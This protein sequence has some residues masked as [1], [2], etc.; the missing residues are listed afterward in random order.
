MS[1]FTRVACAVLTATA[2]AAAA[3][4]TAT[5]AERLRDPDRARD[6]VELRAGECLREPAATQAEGDADVTPLL[7]RAQ[8]RTR[9]NESEDAS[10][11]VRVRTGKQSGA[12]G[13]LD[14]HASGTPGARSGP[15]PSDCPC[16]EPCTRD[17]QREQVRECEGEMRQTR[18]RE[19]EQAGEQEQVR[20]QLS[21]GPDGAEGSPHGSMSGPSENGEAGDGACTRERTRSGQ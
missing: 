4:G 19:Q 15:G 20:E 10:G 14:E 2:L 17:Q 5:G 21:A 7:E 16:D 12:G 13:P 1:R 8:E 6:R 9:V 3:A 18:T 11:G